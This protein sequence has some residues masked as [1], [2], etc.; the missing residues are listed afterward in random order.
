MESVYVVR[1][2]TSP[3]LITNSLQGLLPSRHQPIVRHRFTVLDTFDGR[4]RRA[5][6]RLRRGGG[7]GPST[8]VWQPI[9]GGQ[10][11][12]RVTQPVSFVW[13]LPDG[14][15][16][17]ALASVV[18]VRRLLAQADIEQFG[19]L[20]EI[21]DDRGKTVARLRIESGRARLPESRQPW[22]VLAHGHLPEGSARL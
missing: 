20:L 16:Q 4:V 13:D 10:L 5:G 1:G 12:L 17:Q 18:G 15:L 6:G 19:S 9:D 2:E 22:Q 21:L 8:I 11:T 7:N 14:P 3:E